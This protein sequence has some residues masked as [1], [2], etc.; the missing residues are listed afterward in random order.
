M[1]QSADVQQAPDGTFYRN[2]QNGADIT[3]LR[4]CEDCWQ[5][6]PRYTDFPR[7]LVSPESDGDAGGNGAK[8]RKTVVV[9]KDGIEH[10]QKVVCL[11]CY[12]A[13][14][15]R[16]YPGGVRPELRAVVIGP[17]QPVEVTVGE[18]TVEIPAV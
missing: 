6:I 17:S 13:A 5:V 2:T 7:G 1:E 14:F 18:A 10:L 8:T 11:S 12:F 3:A 4:V 15:D 16:V 9:E